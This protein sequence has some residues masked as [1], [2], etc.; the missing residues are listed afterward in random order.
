MERALEGILREHGIQPT[1]QRM[2]VAEYVLRTDEHPTADRVWERVKARLPA[3]SRATVYNTLNLLIEKGLLRSYVLTEG[4][5]VFDP[6]VAPHHHFIDAE[7]GVISDLPWDALQV[8]GL[9]ELEGFDVEDFQVV[10]RG[11]KR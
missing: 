4:A 11:R 1:S 7:S 3:V 8:V 5:Q 10:L 6:K 9:E 2:A